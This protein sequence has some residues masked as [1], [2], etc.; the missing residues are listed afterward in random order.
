MHFKW[1]NVASLYCTAP[2]SRATNFVDF[3]NFG[4]IHKICFTENHKFYRDKDYREDTNIDSFPRT[5]FSPFAKFV[6]LEKRH[7][8]V[9]SYSYSGPINWRTAY[10]D[11]KVI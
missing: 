3:M 6:A 5:S 1:W 11:F 7:P 4:D 10:I 8:T 2:F 9:Y